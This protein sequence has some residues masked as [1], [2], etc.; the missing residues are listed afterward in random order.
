MGLNK[1][2]IDQAGGAAGFVNTDNFA[3]V[4]YTGNGGTKS[5]S[6]LDFQP[7]L[8]WIKRRDSTSN[9]SLTDSVRGATWELTSNDANAQNNDIDAV[10]SFDSNGFTLG[11]DG[12]VNGNGNTLVAWCWKAGGTA[13]SNT[14][15]TNT[16]SVSANQDAGFSIVRTTGITADP[17][18]YGHGLAAAPELIIVKRTDGTK[19]W[20]VYCEYIPITKTLFLNSASLPSTGVWNSTAPTST[21]FSFDGLATGQDLVAYCFHS[22]DSYQKIGEYTGTG[23]AGNVV[24]TGFRPRFLLIKG[25]D[26]GSASWNIFDS[27]RSNTGN[28]INEVLFP[29]LLSAETTNDSSRDIDFNDDNFTLDGTNNNING[30]GRGYIYLAIA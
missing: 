11:A 24:T 6:S 28:P 3:P 30:S 13:V 18:T 21:V 2:L 19:E 23:A 10:T 29:D 26:T 8:V 5:I 9:N 4:T 25:K 14:D 12:N 20:Q 16:T 22:V 15:G 1:R 17:G 7:D 27:A